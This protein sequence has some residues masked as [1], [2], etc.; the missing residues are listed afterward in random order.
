[1]PSF[2]HNSVLG[3]KSASYILEALEED[4][5]GSASWVDRVACVSDFH[6]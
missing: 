2:V 3:V 5:F 1:M 4:R 6:L